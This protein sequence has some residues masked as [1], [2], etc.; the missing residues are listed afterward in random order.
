M[1]KRIPQKMVSL[2]VVQ[3]AMVEQVTI[4]N[5]VCQLAP[6]LITKRVN[7]LRI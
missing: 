6:S 2:A 4:L 3:I 7:Q 1:P 5:C